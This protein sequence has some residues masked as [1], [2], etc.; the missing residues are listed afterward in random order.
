MYVESYGNP[1]YVPRVVL[2]Q[3]VAKKNTGARSPDE[4]NPRLHFDAYAPH[5]LCSS[6]QTLHRGGSYIK[7]IS[8]PVR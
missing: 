1:M 8:R 7:A 4:E 6:N 2:G 5:L 3:D